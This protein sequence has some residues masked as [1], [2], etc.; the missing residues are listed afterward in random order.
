M[1]LSIRSQ[2]PPKTLLTIFFFF[3]RHHLIVVYKTAFYSFYLPVALAMRFSGITNEASYAQALDI[4]L[5]LGEYFQVQDDFLDCYG[6]PEVIGKIGTDILD[7]KCGWLINAALEK[8]SP[9][10]RKTLDVSFMSG[11]VL[12]SLLNHVLTS[13]VILRTITDRSH[14]NRKQKSRL[15]SRSWSYNLFS[16]SMKQTRT[17]RLTD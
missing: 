2:P 15:S 10:Q 6:A 7:N 11:P 12:S 1:C 4:L 17:P 8:A 3:N 14:P 5:P 16:R 9:E 13:H